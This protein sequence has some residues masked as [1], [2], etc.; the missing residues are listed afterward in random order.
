LLIRGEE[1]MRKLASVL[2]SLLL[3]GCARLTS[4]APVPTQ[5]LQP[6]A[7]STDMPTLTASETALPTDAPRPTSTQAPPTPI[8]T[9]APLQPGQPITLT[10]LHMLTATTGWGVES[11]GHLLRTG[12]GGT[13]WRD[14]TPPQSGIFGFLDATHAW[15]TLKISDECAQANDWSSY[16]RCAP[17]SPVVIWRTADGGQTWQQSVPFD[18][19]DTHYEPVAIQFVDTMTGWFLFVEMFGPMGSHDMGLLRTDDAGATWVRA[20]S[21]WSGF[22]PSRGMIFASAQD[23]WTGTDCRFVPITGNT[24][25]EF[26]NGEAISILHTS[27]GGSSLEDVDLPP[28]QVI[29]PEITGAGDKMIFC[30]ITRMTPISGRAFSL[31]ASCSVTQYDGLH[32]VLGY[33]TPDG[34]HTWHSWLASGD[35]YFVNAATGW[36]LY[37]EPDSHLRR[38]QKTADG[39]RTWNTFVTVAWETAQ[40]DFVS[41]QVGW[42]V[43]AGAGASALV[44]TTDGG[45]IWTEIRP[46][47][48]AGH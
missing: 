28:P 3:C 34:G 19:R 42:A 25:Q 22:C 43:V 20:A 31:E 15:A 45:R 10:N 2:L 29:P 11:S 6:T 48:A 1:E 27:D 40:F 47:V 9:L 13:T 33:L 36:R 32:F 23:G 37:T 16:Q 5:T 35:E 44:H 14:V 46:V 4:S 8:S 7:R 26:I 38:L 21:N 24:S 17:V 12:D 41:E 39:G 30:G 18:T